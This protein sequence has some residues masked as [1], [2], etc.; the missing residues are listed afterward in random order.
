MNNKILTLFAALCLILISCDETTEGI[1]TSLTD[2]V[3]HLEV[4]ASLFNV[5]SRSVAV[6]SVVSRNTTGYLGRIRDPETGAYITGD[7]M[8]QFNMLE[9]YN[10]EKKDSIVSRDEYGEIIADSCEIRL[11]YTSYY[12]DSLAT[13][14]MTVHEMSRPMTEGVIYYSD[15][16]PMENGYVREGGLHKSHTYTLVNTSELDEKNKE[17]KTNEDPYVNNIC[18]RLNEPYTDRNGVTYNNFGTYIIRTYYDHPEYF[19]NSDQF[20]RNVLPGLYFKMTGGL[21]SMA[22]ITVPQLN[23][24][25]SVYSNGKTTSHTTLLCGTEEILQ[26]TKVTNDPEII[27][28]LVNDGSC[29]YMY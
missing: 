18:I 10:L 2:N 5:T 4:A 17:R 11:F 1:G 8:T 14:K 3:D 26:T 16:D 19:K 13:M 21:G 9:G 7:F 29:T 20:I 28:Q 12:G 22:Y 15:F 6:D 25:Y 23:I 24:Y 27:N